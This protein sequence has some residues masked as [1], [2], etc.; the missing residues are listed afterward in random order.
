M[1]IRRLDEKTLK[2]A[3]QLKV[4]SWQ[5]ESAGRFDEPLD[6]REEYDFYRHWMQSEKAHQDRR[7]M[8][9]VF[10]NEKLAATLF[11]SFAE[12]EDDPKAFEING[13]FVEKSYRGRQLSLV[14]IR[15][16]LIFYQALNKQ[17]MIV[18]NHKYA[19]SNAFFHALGGRVIRQDNQLEGRLVVDVFSFDV[20]TLL[21]YINRKLSV[22]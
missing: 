14:L 1:N 9:G 19:P 8:L 2:A 5:E 12:V 6:D 7:L 17:N 20:V 11:A 22:R 10:D 16:A 3:I 21:N 15:E 13:I 18:Y 4:K